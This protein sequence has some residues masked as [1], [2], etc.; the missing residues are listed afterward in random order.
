MYHPL[1]FLI[2][3]G[4]PFALSKMIVIVRNHT[5]NTDK[6][7]VDN[8]RP[9]LRTALPNIV[10]DAHLWTRES[11]WHEIHDAGLSEWKSLG[12]RR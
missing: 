3:A 10:T 1:L 7:S 6:Q 2:A 9:L 4:L 5:H 8:D 12:K 11:K